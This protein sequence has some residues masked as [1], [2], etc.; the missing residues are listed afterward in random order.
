MTEAGTDPETAALESSLAAELG[1]EVTGTEVLGDGL[2]LLIAVSTASGEY[3]V[4]RPNELREASYIIDLEDE[5]GVMQRLQ[6]TSIP[7]PEP[8]LFCEDEAVL[9]DSFFV[10]TALDGEAVQLG[11][12]LPERLQ[13]PRARRRVAQLL[14]DTL[15]EIHSLPVVPFEEVCERH[16]P[17]GQVVRTLDRLDAATRVTGHDPPA[18]R[19]VG[20]WLE[21]NAPVEPE[22]T[23]LHGD[24]RPGNVLL[25]G[26]RPEVAG[27]LDWETA[28]LGDPLTELGYLL[29]RW[30]DDGDPT[31]PLGE[32][33]ARYPNSDALRQLRARNERGL[34]PFTNRAG[35]PSRRELVA[36]Y[37]QKTGRSFENDRFYRALA[38]FMLATVWEDLHRHRREAGLS[39]D[40][41]PHVEYVAMLAES[42]VSGELR[43]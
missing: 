15:A 29:L 16:T 8:V 2:N 6:D 11:E 35:S 1:V 41:E 20:E 23:L 39:S 43:L 38:A 36:R 42:I 19:A 18:L 14:V 25:A 34:S 28:L 31:P 30:R 33:E 13:N 22:T 7:V 37:E 40:W 17:R 32:L 24:F 26:E 9:G 21:R 4:R 3:V 12:D 27:V 5:Y 10:M